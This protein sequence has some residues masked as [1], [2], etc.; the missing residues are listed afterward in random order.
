M[1]ALAKLYLSDLSYLLHLYQENLMF[2]YEEVIL[3]TKVESNSE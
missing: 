3:E 1:K 2:C